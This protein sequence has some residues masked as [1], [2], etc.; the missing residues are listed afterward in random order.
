[1]NKTDR[2]KRERK[3]ANLIA[4]DRTFLHSPIIPLRIIIRMNFRMKFGEKKKRFHCKTHS[5][6]TSRKSKIFF[7][8]TVEWRQKMFTIY[9]CIE[10]N[11]YW[12]PSFD[13][14]RECVDGTVVV[15][16]SWIV[17][18]FI[19]VVFSLCSFSFYLGQT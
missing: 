16:W 8:S 9:K 17:F 11:K 5:R 6:L 12:L 2:G 4:N 7:L 19:F 15:M 10:I 1:M 3:K 13:M 18:Y 14:V